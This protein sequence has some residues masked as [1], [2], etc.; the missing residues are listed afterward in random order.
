MVI[1]VFGLQSLDLINKES[2]Q[3][4]VS[5]AGDQYTWAYG[6]WSYFCKALL[7]GCEDLNADTNE[8]KI[9]DLGELYKYIKDWVS[10]HL[11]KDQDAQMYPEGSTFPIVEY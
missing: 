3:V 7:E 1:D 2:Y 11:K 9:V 8:D 5:C 10:E 6:T 4:L